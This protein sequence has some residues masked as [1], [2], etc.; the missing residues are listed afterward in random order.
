M[1]KNRSIKKKNFLALIACLMI[2]TAALPHILMRYFTTPSVHEA[3]VSVFWS[4]ASFAVSG[5]VGIAFGFFP[6]WK[7]AQLDPIDALR[8]E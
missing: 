8:Y 7:A 1:E 2:G 5:L 3:R 4:L 6:A